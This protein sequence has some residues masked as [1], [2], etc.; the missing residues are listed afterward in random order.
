M[1]LSISTL[2]E[3]SVVEEIKFSWLPNS[4]PDLAGYKIYSGTDQ[5]NYDTEI[6]VGMGVM[7]GGRVTAKLPRRPGRVYYAATAYNTDGLESD[8][9]EEVVDEWLPVPEF[10]MIK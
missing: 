8:Y 2:I 1:L 3:A 4:E 9:S 5:G 10:R 7:E 6:D